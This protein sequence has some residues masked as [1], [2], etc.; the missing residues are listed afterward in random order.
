MIV[1]KIPNQIRNLKTLRYPKFQYS[2]KMI[3]ER[4][5]KYFSSLD[6]GDEGIIYFSFPWTAYYAS[7]G[8]YLQ[9][10]VPAK[11]Y[12][13]LRSQYP[14]SLIFTVCQWDGGPQIPLQNC[15]VFAS[16]G[17]F[18]S[19]YEDN[20]KYIP[21][22][23]LANTFRFD[24]F[25]PYFLRKRKGEFRGRNTFGLRYKMVE[26]LKYSKFFSM[27]IS[28]NSPFEFFNTILFY[29]GLCSNI[30]T[31]APR[32]YGPAS[33]RMYEAIKLG[34]IPIYISDEKWLPFEEELDWKSISIISSGDNYNELEKIVVEKLQTK[35]YLTMHNNL[36][37]VSKE[38]ISWQGTLKYIQRKVIQEFYGTRNL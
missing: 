3:E 14:T 13:E 15:L 6:D 24:L 9:T 2:Y 34:S 20:S 32:G 18:D 27:R 31:L 8:E 16:S 17:N 19:I 25:V 12:S 37:M 38:F 7:N 1:S 26:S 33:F 11:L 5:F 36:K 29:F 21:I 4:S 28:K 22:P 10:N 30:F 35:Q 23:L